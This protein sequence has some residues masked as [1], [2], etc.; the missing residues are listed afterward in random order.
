MANGVCKLTG[1]PGRFVRSHLI[2]FALTKPD[3]EG[4]TAN[5]SLAVASAPFE[6]GQV[7]MTII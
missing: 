5:F 6:G 2:P 4:R 3:M 7:G 1:Q